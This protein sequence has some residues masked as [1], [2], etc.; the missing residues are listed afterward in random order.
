MENY[1]IQNTKF[2]IDPSTIIRKEKFSVGDTIKLFKKEYSD[3]W[4]M[5]YGV[6]VDFNL[7]PDFANIVILYFED[8]YN[9]EVKIM[10]VNS[11]STELKIAPVIKE[12]MTLSYDTIIESFQN[13]IIAKEREIEEMKRK[14][15]YFM[16]VWNLKQPI[17][18]TQP[19]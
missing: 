6:I 13:N 4:K 9:P 1:E 2:E 7:F 16:K 5:F 12:Q 19:Y 17:Q 15:K 14:Q 10:D 8:G 3:S 18:T 11:K